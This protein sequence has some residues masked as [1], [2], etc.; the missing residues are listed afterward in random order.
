M[1]NSNRYSNSEKITIDLYDTFKVHSVVLQ[2]AVMNISGPFTL[3]GI[4][5]DFMLNNTIVLTRNNISLTGGTTQNTCIDANVIITPTNCNKIII[6]FANPNPDGWVFM[7]EIRINCLSNSLEESLNWL[8]ITANK[9]IRDSSRTMNNGIIAYPP[10]VGTGYEAF[11]LRDYAYMLQ[12]SSKYA[13]T[14]NELL[15]S[16]YLFSNGQRN[17]GAQLDCVKFDGVPIYMPGYG[18]MGSN[19]VLDGCSMFIDVVYQTYLATGSLKLIENLINKCELAIDYVPLVDGIPYISNVGWD[20][21]PYGFTD[22]VRK[23][24]KQ[25]FDGLLLY[26]TYLQMA[27]LYTVLN[28]TTK[29]TE[30][31]NLS[32]ALKTS[33]NNTFWNSSIGLYKAS[34]E[35]CSINYDIWGSAFAVRLGVADASIANIIANY[36]NTNYSGIINRGQLRHLPANTFW[37][38]TPTAQGTYQ[39]GAFW[40]TPIG[41]FVY[42]LDLVNPT[43]ADN[44]VIDLVNFYQQFG[45][46]E[47][48]NGNTLTLN[49]YVCNATLPIEGIIAMINRRNNIT[50]SPIPHSTW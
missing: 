29:K 46:Y 2:Q 9:L 30:Y 33:I 28:N 7:G 26:Q 13:F 43:L 10:Q 49:N 31:E 41:W 15:N 4:T 35:K 16:V 19:P 20:R 48:S 39:N 18:S 25:F 40:G 42:T 50:V 1:N 32:I 36:F 45:V 8:K 12:G 27:Y 17:D 22:T 3:N 6:K 21:C 11:W 23:T 37:E 44:T 24:G 34:T 38:D 5:I 14:Y 47:W